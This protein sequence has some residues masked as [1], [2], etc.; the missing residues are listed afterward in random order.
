MIFTYY[1]CIQH[2]TKYTFTSI[3]THIHI[4]IYIYLFLP[5]IYIYIYIYNY[6]YYLYTYHF[7]IHHL[8]ISARG[9]QRM[10]WFPYIGPSPGAGRTAAGDGPT[11]EAE[12]AGQLGETTPGLFNAWEMVGRREVFTQKDGKHQKNCCFMLFYVFFFDLLAGCFGR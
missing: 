9:G 2:I 6:P 7:S 3:Y 10:S 12:A 1:I 11:K 4:Y 5:Q 8:T